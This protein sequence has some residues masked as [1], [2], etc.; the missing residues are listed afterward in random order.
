M[1]WAIPEK[2][3]TRVQGSK[4]GIAKPS[5]HLHP[6]PF[7]STQLYSLPPSLFQP[8]HGSLQHPQRYKSQNNAHNWA[9]FPNLG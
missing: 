5:T 7:T 4:M 1:D 2:I 6:A 8:P 3:Q 9:F